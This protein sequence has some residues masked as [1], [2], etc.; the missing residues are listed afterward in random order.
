MWCEV[1]LVVIYDLF[2]GGFYMSIKEK[3]ISDIQSDDATYWSKNEIYMENIRNKIQNYVGEKNISVTK[4]AEEANISR[5]T[6]YDITP[7][8]DKTV[9]LKTMVGLCQA[10][11]C[12]L[13]EL[14]S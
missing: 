7:K 9:T 5:K 12:S 3:E 11:G 1:T 4:L 2:Q 8:T 6:I 13:R 10:M 14:I